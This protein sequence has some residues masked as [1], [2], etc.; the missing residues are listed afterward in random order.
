MNNCPTRLFSLATP[1]GE[2]MARLLKLLALLLTLLVKRADSTPTTRDTDAMATALRILSEAPLIDGHND[3]PLQLRRLHPGGIRGVNLTSINSTQTNLERIRRGNVSA[4][5]WSAYT[6]CSTQSLDAVRLT[7]EQIDLIHR[8]V[9]NSAILRLALTAQ[10]IRAAWRAGKVSSLIGVE[11]GH[12]IDS[13]LGAL[14]TLHRL[15]ARYMSL[16]HDCNTPWADTWLVDVGKVQPRSH[17]L[18]TF[19]KA[20]VREMN[21]LGMMVDLS[22]TS[23]AT[24]HAALGVSKAPVIFSHSA[25]KQLCDHGRNVPDELLKALASNGGIVM[26]NFYNKFTSCGGAPSI[27]TVADH[28][29][30]VKSVAGYTAV[31]F[32]SDFDGVMSFPDGLKDP[33]GFPLLV[34]ELVRRRWNDTELKAALGGNLLRV[35]EQVEE[36]SRNHSENVQ[37]D[38]IPVDELGPELKC[39]TAYGHPQMV[40]SRSR[41]SRGHGAHQLLLV[42]PSLL[43]ALMSARDAH[44]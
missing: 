19:G 32:G 3:W 34:A 12:S 14:R 6:M 33:S 9:E 28:F 29:D 1:V 5:F 7:L 22:H 30:H 43:L 16:T 42:L 38:L 27:A 11:G 8:V 10:D 20:V 35:M 21:R 18:S 25:A 17:G 26:I 39:R 2:R 37:E 40:P 4:Q 15:G 44:S 31:G 41:A 36:V 24:A 23:L 13:S